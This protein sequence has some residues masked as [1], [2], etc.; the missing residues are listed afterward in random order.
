MS[1]NATLGLVKIMER[2]EIPSVP[3]SVP[4]RNHGQ[5]ATAKVVSNFAPSPTFSYIYFFIL[6]WTVET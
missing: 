1:T 5:V 2:V 4:V 6:M 3:T